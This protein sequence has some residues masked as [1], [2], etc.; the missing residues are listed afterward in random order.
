MKKGFTLIELIICIAI[1]SIGITIVVA[2]ISVCYSDAKY[3]IC[4]GDSNCKYV[5]EYTENDGCVSFEKTKICGN[6]T[7]E[8]TKVIDI[9]GYLQMYLNMI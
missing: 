6:Y 7:I 8:N 1:V 2:S 5:K 4:D 3:F 9:F